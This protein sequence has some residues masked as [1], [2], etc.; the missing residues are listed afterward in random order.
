MHQSFKYRLY[1]NKRQQQLIDETLEQCRLIYNRLFAERKE[2]YE[3]SGKM[4][5]Y[6]AQA[7]S[8]PARKAAIPVLQFCPFA[9]VAGCR[10]AVG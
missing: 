3:K 9:G 1:P 5:S 8:F 4:L 2:A 7:N 6:V 10:E